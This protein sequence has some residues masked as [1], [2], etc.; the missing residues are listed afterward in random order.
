MKVSVANKGCD[1]RL[2]LLLLLT[3][4]LAACAS[5]PAPISSRA[6]P[7]S[8]KLNHHV[9]APGDTLF[10]IAWRYEKDMD[11][12]AR[13][14]GLTQPYRLFPGQRLAL[15]TSV[16]VKPR[17][18]P[19]TSVN[20]PVEPARAS[21]INE[22]RSA[23]KRSAPETGT[24]SKTA[25]ASTAIKPAGGKLRWQWPAKGAVSRHYDRGRVFKG[26][27]IQALPGRDVQAAADGVVAYAGSGLRGYGKLIIIK[28]S[29]IYLSAYA[30]NKTIVVK[31]GQRI[32]AGDKIGSI[33]GD[34]DNRGR[35]YFELR[36]NGRPID[37]TRLLPRL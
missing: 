11:A 23:P 37:P 35:L 5:N 26:I 20:K 29:G 33:G 6:Q 15:D 36:K 16:V 7:P 1:K 19:T 28:H 4:Y 30:H 31:E 2:G 18:A 3:L 8:E 13:S 22:S 10:S 25:T 21:V 17:S 32:R 12:L 14:N 27:N 24:V 9:V 34:P